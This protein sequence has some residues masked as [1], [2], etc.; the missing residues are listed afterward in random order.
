V[1]VL[2]INAHGQDR[3]LGGVEKGLT[4]LTRGLSKRGHSISWITA[5]PSQ[6]VEGSTGVTAMHKTDWRVDPF[7][8]LQTHVDAFVSRPSPRLA[9][10]IAEDCP[11]VVHTHNLPGLTTAVWEAARR[12]G[13]PVLHTLHDYYLLCPRTTLMRRDGHTP[14]RPNPLM[15]GLRTRRLA[16]WSG[17][18]SHLAGVSKFLLGMHAHLFPHSTKHVIRNPLVPFDSGSIPPPGRELRSIGYIGSLGEPKGVTTLLEA[19]PALGRLGFELHIAGGGRLAEKVQRAAER[20][21]S[22]TYH[23]VVYRESKDAFLAEC[24]LGVIPSTWAEPGGPTHG[25]VEWLCAGRPVLVSPRGGL[26][27]VIDDHPGALA[28]EPEVD[29]IIDTVSS[30]RPSAAWQALVDSVDRPSGE[31]DLERWVAEHEAVYRA[32]AC[33]SST[34]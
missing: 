29:A 30:L 18:V 33:E 14:C 17:G 13:L 10:A 3:A 23:G 26:G 19:A 16:R 34:S 6:P 20:V 9:R 11:D 31:E 2:I 15:C 5:F 12:Q 27:E 8:R 21:P 32:M 7:R 25:M 28:C 22:L 4:M 24:D 1:R